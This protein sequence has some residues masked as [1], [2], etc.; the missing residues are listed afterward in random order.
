MENRMNALQA[1]LEES[2]ISMQ[3]KN[4]LKNGFVRITV[5]FTAHKTCTACYGYIVTLFGIRFH[6]AI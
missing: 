6:T 4:P 5:G 2:K 3:T 1:T